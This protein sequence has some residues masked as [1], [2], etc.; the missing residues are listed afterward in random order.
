M[1]S[2]WLIYYPS[3]ECN[4]LASHIVTK[5]NVTRL[6]KLR[7]FSLFSH[8]NIFENYIRRVRVNAKKM[9]TMILRSCIARFIITLVFTIIMA[10]VREG[11]V[12]SRVTAPHGHIFSLAQQT[13]T[14]LYIR[15]HRPLYR[16]L[17]TSDRC[18]D[19]SLST[20]SSIVTIVDIVVVTQWFKLLTRE[21]LLSGTERKTTFPLP[22]DHGEPRSLPFF[23]FYAFFFSFQLFR[24]ID[25]GVN[26]ICANIWAARINTYSL[27]INRISAQHCLIYFR[28]D[29][30]F[31]CASIFFSYIKLLI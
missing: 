21:T 4:N 6:E 20:V 26:V 9:Q 22:C 8:C 7:S 19:P 28:A 10:R 17:L 1:K 16:S 23:L 31:N 2:N 29:S 27:S 12:L 5:W 11:S 14:L 3:P 30:H 25:I 18:G 24:K 15:T 13:P